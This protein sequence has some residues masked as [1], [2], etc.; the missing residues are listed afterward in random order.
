VCAAEVATGC[1]G[2]VDVVWGVRRSF[3]H[4]GDYSTI[5]RGISLLLL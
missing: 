3:F 2:P 5:Q 1:Y 4:G